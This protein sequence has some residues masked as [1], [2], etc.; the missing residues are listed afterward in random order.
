MTNNLVFEFN[1]FDSFLPEDLNWVGWINNDYFSVN[2]TMLEVII[3]LDLT[4]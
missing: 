3:S 2:I 4:D 1:Y